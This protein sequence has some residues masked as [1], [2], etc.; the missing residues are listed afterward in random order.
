MGLAWILNLWWLVWCQD[1]AKAE[2]LWCLDLEDP[3][4]AWGKPADFA[5]SLEPWEPPQC[6]FLRGKIWC[7][8]LQQS[9]VLTS[10]SFPHTGRYLSTPCWLG[11]EWE[12]DADNVKASLLLSSLTCSYFCV[13]PSCCNLSLELP[14]SC[15]GIFVH[16]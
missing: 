4:G 2:V 5:W 14:S 12:G 9:P 13:T 3:T 6:G 16:G 11:L 10:L 7:W 15:E 8:D 1:R